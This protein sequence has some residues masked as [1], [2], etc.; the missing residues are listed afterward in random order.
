MKIEFIIKLTAFGLAY[1]TYVV[2][3]KK[4]LL[5]FFIPLLICIIGSKLVSLVE[6]GTFEGQ[7]NSGAFLFGYL[8]FVF[9]YNSKNNFLLLI[10]S[11]IALSIGKWACLY[12]CD[13]CIGIQ[14]TS[15]IGIKLSHCTN[16]IGKIYP[17]PIYD[18]IFFLFLYFI[19]LFRLKVEK[20][21]NYKFEFNLFILI[22][23]IY[24]I[25]IEV[26]RI[27]SKLYYG[28]TINQIVYS[29]ILAFVTLNLISQKI[30]KT[31]TN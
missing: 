12:L 5:N 4:S 3:F 17:V 13:S 8:Y 31:G 29:I 6:M 19:G 28:L 26:I 23:C 16:H 20:I 24:N 21:E 30:N 22:I 15:F 2:H 10:S 9:T 1:L 7:R 25:L 27:K 14:T 11:F 18:S